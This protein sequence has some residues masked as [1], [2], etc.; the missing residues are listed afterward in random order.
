MSKVPKNGAKS[1]AQTGPKHIRRCFIPNLTIVSVLLDELATDLVALQAPST[2]AKK[3]YDILVA[4]TI[5]SSSDSD[6]SLFGPHI[7]CDY[8]S[9]PWS[10][11]I[12]SRLPLLRRRNLVWNSFRIFNLKKPL[13][14]CQHSACLCIQQC[15]EFDAWARSTGPCKT[16]SGK[17]HKQPAKKGHRPVLGSTRWGICILVILFHLEA[18][19]H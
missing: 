7:D 6:S 19:Q 9:C 12:D 4:H 15:C 1:Q 14:L 18:F 11:Q 13:G 8:Q 17:S 2:C 3:W 10:V 16:R 5:Y